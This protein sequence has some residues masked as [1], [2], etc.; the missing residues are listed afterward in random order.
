LM[1][2]MMMTVDVVDMVRMSIV[3]MMLMHALFSYYF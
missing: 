1:I 2:V 3:M